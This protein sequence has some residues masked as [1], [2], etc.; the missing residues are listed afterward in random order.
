MPA[1]LHIDREDA[2]PDLAHIVCPVRCQ[3]GDILLVT[4]ELQDHFDT[5]G[6][7]HYRPMNGGH[8]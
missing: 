3:C 1:V 7:V 4:A 2:H 6:H 5:T 8:T